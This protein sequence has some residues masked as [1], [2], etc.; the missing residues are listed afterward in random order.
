MDAPSI[1]LS[2][3]QRLKGEYNDT[4][5][6]ETEKKVSFKDTS[7]THKSP[8]LNEASRPPQA[9]SVQDHFEIVDRVYRTVTNNTD[10]YAPSCSFE[11]GDWHG[12][13]AT[14]RAISNAPTP[15]PAKPEFIFEPTTAA[16]VHNSAVLN[17]FNNDFGQLITQQPEPTTL[18]MG[19]ELRPIE[20]LDKLLGHHPNYKL[21]RWNT[22]RGVDYPISEIDETTREQE[23]IRQIEK[24][25]HKSALAPE[26][27][28]HV[29][30]AMKSDIQLG[31][32]IP[33]TIDSIKKLKHAEVYPVG[34]QHQQTINELGQ[35]IPKKRISHDLSNRKD[36]GLSINQRV[37]ESLLPSVLYGYSLMRF[38]HLIHQ[39][40][41]QHPGERI[42]CN[43]IDIEKAYRRFHTTPTI[44]AKC[45]AIWDREDDESIAILLSRL[46]FG[47][48]P[49]PAHFSIGSDITCDLAND[50]IQCHLWDPTVVTNPLQHC[51]PKTKLL[52][53]DCQFEEAL[54]S[55]VEIPDTTAGVEGYIDDLATAVLDSESNKQEVIRAQNAVLMALHLQFR[56]HAGTSEP[57]ERPET[58]S[59]RKLEAEGGLAEVITYLGW[60]INTRTFK[61][62]LPGDKAK[63]WS[64]AIEQL[65][66]RKTPV[67]HSEM[68]TTVGRINHIGFII[69]QARHFINRLRHEETKAAKH[70]STK[71]SAE[72]KADLALWLRFID[73]AKTGISINSIIFRKPTSISITDACETGMGG[74]DPLTGKMWR[75]TFTK[76]EQVSF[77]LNTKE[78][79][80]A[81]ISQELSLQDD[82]SP[83][84]CHLNIGDSK[85]AEAWLYKS[86]HDPLSQPVQNAIAR[87]M[88]HNLIANKACNYSQHLKGEEN[89]IADSLSRDTHLTIEE[90]THLLEL[91]DHPLKPQL[92]QISHL[93]DPIISWIGSLAQ[94]QHKKRELLWQH[95][96][97]TIAA[98]PSGLPS[99]KKSQ[100]QTHT[101][102]T[103]PKTN[104]TQSSLSSW[105]Q[106]RME[107]ST[108][109]TSLSSAQLRNRPPIMYVRSSNLVVGQT[110]G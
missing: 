97:S 60:T 44:S 19:S 106:S 18:T 27:R 9:I 11:P 91:T 69:P 109:T 66:T 102:S 110:H 70:R 88:A 1:L 55:D 99:S 89:V 78:F 12:F 26:A 107:N 43:K 59:K 58:A 5:L 77:T 4:N 28:I 33:L 52:E 22:T 15:T 63:A 81:A 8:T 16:A 84:P 65:I 29:D 101:S 31:Y 67:Q 23:L 14:V 72:S 39:I 80:A 90:H 41:R 96:P 38:L 103:S 46:P 34:L 47:S 104:A 45:I 76:E 85:V 24:G 50:L 54:E 105:I 95:T 48:S 108:N 6:N 75:Y 62:N 32:G 56:P 40:R 93:S 92:F 87:R 98:G 100:Q 49:A 53:A 71:L 74:Y 82:D 25:N 30:K 68:M 51:I 20:Q 10:D 2:K 94:Y 37:N 7:Q 42:L 36:E 73:Y 35:I 57:I 3:K 79:L 13:M 83:Y 64:D 21:F 86:N 61:I 17:K